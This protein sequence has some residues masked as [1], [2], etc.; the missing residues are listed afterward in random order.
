MTNFSRVLLGSF[1][2]A[3][4]F[5]LAHSSQSI[6]PSGHSRPHSEQVCA[7]VK[8]DSVESSAL[9]QPVTKTAK[10]RQSNARR[11]YCLFMGMTRV[12]KEIKYKENKTI[13][14]I[15]HR[16]LKVKG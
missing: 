9:L 16:I 6:C 3:A 8:D 13:A 1:S 2:R 12:R 7:T 15:Y 11:W 5:L 10:A 4:S 14:S